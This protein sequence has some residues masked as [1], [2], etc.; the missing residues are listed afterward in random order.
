[1]TVEKHCK[2]MDEVASALGI[3]TEQI[4]G[5]NPDEASYPST[6]EIEQAETRV[7]EVVKADGQKNIDRAVQE[8]NEAIE[9]DRQRQLKEEEELF[10]SQ[11]RLSTDV[12]K[13]I[14]EKNKKEKESSF[15]INDFAVKDPFVFSGKNS[16]PDKLNKLLNDLYASGVVIKS[17][18]DLI[19]YID[20]RQFPNKTMKEIYQYTKFWKTTSRNR[21]QKDKYTCQKCMH[22]YEPNSRGKCGFLNVHHLTYVRLYYEPLEDL[23]TLCRNCHLQWHRDKKSG[24]ILPGPDLRIESMGFW[25]KQLMGKVRNLITD[26]LENRIIFINHIDRRYEPKAFELAMQLLVDLR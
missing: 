2:T 5:F 18:F 1:M 3:T 17:F 20:V 13:Q 6:A 4:C 7:N 26:K 9:M 10:L 24:L 19:P 16:Y 22:Q 15:N 14:Q 25:G 8:V 23:I 21:V 11:L 12:V